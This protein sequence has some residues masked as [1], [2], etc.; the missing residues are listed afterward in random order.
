[1]KHI[2]DTSLKAYMEIQPHLGR[3][4][5]DVLAAIKQHPRCTD[6]ELTFFMGYGY[7]KN[8]VRPRRNKLLELGLIHDAGKRRC[9]LTSMT[10]HVWEANKK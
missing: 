2:A 9:E 10:C 5:A 3:M 6:S 4:E 7:D 1:M 8:K